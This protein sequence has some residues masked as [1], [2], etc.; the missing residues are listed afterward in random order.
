MPRSADVV[1]IGGGIIGASIAYHLV[2]EARH[3]RVLLIEQD[4]T[5]ARA[6]TPLS[7]GGIRQQY[8]VACN[9]AL[10]RYGVEFYA[11]FDERMAAPGVCRK[12]TFTNAATWC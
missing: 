12:P 1:I 10:A 8:S 11:H 9:V 4:M 7:M 3:H 6:A 5:Y 2:Q